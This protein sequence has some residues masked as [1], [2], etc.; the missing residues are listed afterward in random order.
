MA[1]WIRRGTVTAE[2]PEPSVILDCIRPGLLRPFFVR[3]FF[4]RPFLAS[5]GLCSPCCCSPVLC[6]PW[7]A[8][9][10]FCSLVFC[11]PV[12]GFAQFVFALL[13]RRR[14]PGPRSEAHQET[15]RCKQLQRNQKN[16]PRTLAEY[17]FTRDSRIETWQ[18]I[19]G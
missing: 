19:S 5:P 18:K 13:L 6:S 12:F 16:P 14:T 7:F 10:F 4:V 2:I 17:N 11:S 3:L 9:P 8:S 15:E 1:K